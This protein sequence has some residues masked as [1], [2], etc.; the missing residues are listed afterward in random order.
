M[1]PADVTVSATSD[2]VPSSPRR[3]PIRV[4]NSATSTM[5]P[6]ILTITSESHV[7]GMSDYEKIAKLFRS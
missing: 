2:V 4:A 3:S 1:V 6:E 5:V 7:G